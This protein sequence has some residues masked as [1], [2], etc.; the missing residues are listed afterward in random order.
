[1]LLLTGRG[2]R[3]Y[4]ARNADHESL[5]PVV[6]TT[7]R[8]ALP[9]ELS[10]SFLELLC[11]PFERSLCKWSASRVMNTLPPSRTSRSFFF[12]RNRALAAVLRLRLSSAAAI[13]AASLDMPAVLMGE[14][15]AGEAAAADTVRCRLGGGGCETGAGA[16]ACD[17]VDRE[18]AGWRG[19]SCSCES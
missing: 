3:C 12:M 10:D 15:V 16:G 13:A 6:L 14:G 2:G 11:L 5:Q 19:G 4:G 9:L 17:E 18:S 8:L 7:K 1:M